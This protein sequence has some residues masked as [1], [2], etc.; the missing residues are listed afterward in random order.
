[1]AIE[2]A[3]GL[4]YG[5]AYTL[6]TYLESADAASK[7]SPKLLEGIYVVALLPLF[8]H[9]W[10]RLLNEQIFPSLL[11]NVPSVAFRRLEPFTYLI[12]LTAIGFYFELAPSIPLTLAIGLLFVLLQIVVVTISLPPAD[13]SAILIRQE[14]IAFLFL[15]SGFSA[16]IYQT[17]WQRS[18]FSLFGVNSESVTIIVSVFM[19]GLGV[20]ALMGGWLQRR[21]PTRHLMLFLLMETGIGVF[22]LA[23]MDIIQ[24]MGRSSGTETTLSLAA[25]AYLVLF[26]PTLLMGAT[27]PIL[28]AYIQGF[29]RNLGKTTSLLYALNTFGSAIAAFVTVEILFVFLGLR[30][31]VIIAAICNLITAFLVWQVSR[32]LVWSTPGTAIAYKANQSTQAPIVLSFRSAFL[33]LMLGGFIALSQEILWFRIL[34]FM[35]GGKPQTFGLVLTATLCGIACGALQA[36]RLCDKR[37]DM[38]GPLSKT[39]LFAAA[40]FYLS[41]PALGFLAMGLGAAVAVLAAYCLIGLVAYASGLIFPLLI[42]AADASKADTLL[43]VSLLYFANIIGASVGPLFTGFLMLNW[44]SLKQAVLVLTFLTVLTSIIVAIVAKSNPKEKKVQL[45]WI[46]G[47]ALLMV[48]FQP[49]LFSNYLEKLQ[50][51]GPQELPFKH[52]V[53]N[54]SGIITVTRG[55]PVD[56]IYGGGVYDGGFNIN[57]VANSNG[58]DRAYMLAALH[59]QPVN[60]LEIGLSSGSWTKV[61]ASYSPLKRLTVVEI[62][63]GYHQLLG[64]YPEIA[65]VLN[66]AKVSLVYDDGRRWLL[67]NPDMKFDFILM[68]TT[69]HW[70]S[71]ASSLLSRE[72]FELCKEHLTAGGVIY[73]NT[74]GSM[75]AAMTAGMTFRYVTQFRNFVAASDSPFDMTTEERRANLMRFTDDKGAPIFLKDAEHENVGARLAAQD[76]HDMRNEIVNTKGL[77]LITDDNMYVEYGL[78]AK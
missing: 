20:G 23:S 4:A 27:L 34:S 17:A 44:I 49:Y 72:F 38:A 51:D 76:L 65:Q 47:F 78:A 52:V 77:H 71:N 42:Q 37:T 21:F 48:L 62:N 50:F 26:F 45:I 43:R 19:L 9:I 3:A 22:G 40:V 58:I 12:W 69:F 2:I 39:L 60:I 15:I 59:R 11:N 28:I 31:S 1:M 10:R 8:L 7:V 46:A 32:T 5:L 68:N 14:Y 66:N 56:T 33:I 30:T 29:Y 73:F 36:N 75:D 63:S 35:T 54:R 16:L 64:F 70:R 18:L 74:T 57:P 24:G 55:S 41:V 53:E 13:R 6:R 25:K 67:A 61:I